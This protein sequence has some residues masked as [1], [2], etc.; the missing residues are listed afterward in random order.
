VVVAGGWGKRVE[1]SLAIVSKEFP[2]ALLLRYLGLLG[3][4]GAAQPLEIPKLHR[5]KGRWWGVCIGENE[6]FAARSKGH[7][8]EVRLERLGSRG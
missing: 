4:I 3:H 7:R 5:K 8:L 1:G 2:P 6:N